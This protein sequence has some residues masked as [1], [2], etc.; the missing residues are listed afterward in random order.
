MVLPGFLFSVTVLAQTV[1]LSGSWTFSADGYR[2][3]EVRLPGTLDE[4]RIGV[5]NERTDETTHLS[6]LWSYRGPASYEREIE[7]PASWAGKAAYLHLERAK[8]STV[9][10][11]GRECGNSDNISTPQVFALGALT[12]GPHRLLVRVDNGS[13]VP[14]QLYGSSHAYT[15]DT[16]TNWNGILGRIFLSLSP[17]TYADEEIVDNPVFHGFTSDGHHFYANGHLIFLRGKHDACV[18][19]LTGY[20]PMDLEGWMDYLGTCKEYGINHVRFHS[21]CPPDAAFAA[22]DRLGIYMQPELPFWGTFNPRD[23]TLR[24]FLHKEGVNILKTYARH[25]S[26]VMMALGNELGGSV[27]MMKEFVD[28]FRALEPD[29]LYTFGSN[30]SL[31]YQGIKPGMDYFTTCRIG[32]EAWGSYN[33][34]T[35]GSFSF[36]D[37]ADGGMINHFR[38]NSVMAFDEACDAASVPIISH[39]TGQFQTYPDYGEIDKYTG[40]LYPYNF[41]VFRRRLKTAGMEDQAMDFHRASYEWSFRL[42][43]ADVEMDLRTRNM[44]GFQLLDLQDYPGQGSAFVGI[45]DAFMEPKGVGSKLDEWR[46]FCSEVVPLLRSDAFC[47]GAGERIDAQLQVAN[48]GGASLEGKSLEWSICL[49]E[50]VLRQGECSLPAG[51]GLID[52][53]SLHLDVSQ[54]LKACGKGNVRVRLEL[55]VAGTDYRNGYDLW[56]YRDAKI[57]PGKVLV[58]HALDPE[59]VAALEAGARVLW[60]PSSAELGGN[61]VGG[62]FQTDYWNYRMFSSITERKGV[63]TS[64]G[65]LGILTDP[66]LPLFDGFPT[67]FHSDWQWFPVVKESHPV[68]LDGLPRGYRPLVQVIDNVE[69]N[70]RLGLV[71]EFRVGQGSLLLVAS[72]L[73]AASAT[74]EGKAFYASVLAYMN[75]PQF[76]PAFRIGADELLAS[77]SGRRAGPAMEALYNISNY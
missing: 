59:T 27:E 57:R 4:H 61:T 12:A 71:C 8:P 14:P 9:F 54:L 17:D 50:K 32:G 67:S 3:Q 21:W 20:C 46:Q 13:G 58:T 60:M 56:L 68:I 63:E 42:Y 6:R 34:H 38:P 74:P 49:G 18:F 36:A 72:D 22:A 69:R 77:L 53:G 75:S 11:D 5:H 62:L 35:R 23:T 52:A 30:Y 25:P 44:A 47:Y 64:P 39:E 26:F 48:Y 24:T 19:P 76:A 28:D 7:I 2:R 66:A 10:V 29:I 15:E 73:E 43:K 51:E 1:D 41:E 37:A 40:V 31:G 16:Q 65:T 33:T 70:H 45:L 55:G